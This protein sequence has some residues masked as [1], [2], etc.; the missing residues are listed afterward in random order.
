METKKFL[1][2]LQKEKKQYWSN[3]ELYGLF[4]AL[5]KKLKEEVENEKE[6]IEA[7]ASD[8]GYECD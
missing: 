1:D 4:V 5:E 6:D 3:E 8:Y 2:Y 7:N